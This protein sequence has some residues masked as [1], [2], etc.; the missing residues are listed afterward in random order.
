[1]GIRFYCPNGHKLNVKSFLA[2]HR[3][4]CPFCGI[5][6]E[7]PKQSTR[8]EEG[9]E[10][11][12]LPEPGHQPAPKPVPIAGHPSAGGSGVLR[13]PAA[14][15]ILPASASPKPIQKPASVAPIVAAPVAKPAPVAKATPIAQPISTPQAVPVVP[16]AQAAPVI[17][18]AQP[19]PMAQAAPVAQAVPVASQYTGMAATSSN[20][21]AAPLDDSYFAAVQG[22]AGPP[23]VAA[24]VDPFD[25]AP[26][27]VWYVRPP[28][29]GQYGPAAAA[30][31]RTWVQ[32]GRVSADSLVWREGWRDWQ[33]ASV[34]FPQLGP[35]E[36]A[37][38]MISDDRGRISR[39][40]DHGAAVPMSDR[41]RAQRRTKNTQFL[42]LIILAV[43]V[44]LLGIVF[45]A[46]M[47]LK[48]P[49]KPEKP[50]KNE[51]P[52]PTAPADSAES[53]TWLR[54]D[55]PSILLG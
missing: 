32:E 45:V 39:T 22:M 29:G 41:A 42:I 30:V 10:G 38:A 25:E 18:V 21:G 12:V 26:D 23:P 11:D 13:A 8:K 43:T 50:D 3:G 14:S 49:Q 16:V 20:V 27:A 6:V 4:I 35:Q 54:L 53:T 33:E 17:P 31:M 34:V 55:N 48:P 40:D 2:G 1:M 19:M 46:V 9:P 52:A 7:I 15:P 44:L 28:T 24:P 51:R 36:P 37:A 47:M 5:K